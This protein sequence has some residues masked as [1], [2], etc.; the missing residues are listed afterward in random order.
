LKF[1]FPLQYKLLFF[2]INILGCSQYEYNIKKK[3]VVATQK[4]IGKNTCSQV[5]RHNAIFLQLPNSAENYKG[6]FWR[7]NTAT[8]LANEGVT[9]NEIKSISEIIVLLLSSKFYFFIERTQISVDTGNSNSK[10]KSGRYHSRR[11]ECVF[12]IKFFFFTICLPIK[13]Q[14]LWEEIW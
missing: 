14:E 11:D 13:N 3:K 5:S 7:S 2:N 1:Y 10:K 8:L 12:E 4:P 6:Q 9:A